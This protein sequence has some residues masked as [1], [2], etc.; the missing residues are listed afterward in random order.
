MIVQAGASEA[1]RDLAARTAEVIFTA[2][3]TL[4]D[5][6]EFYADVKGRL[7]KYGRSPDDL[8]IMPGAF[9]IIGRTEAEAQEKYEFLQSLKSFLMSPGVILKN[10]YKG[11]DLSK[12]SLDDVAS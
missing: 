1:G 4:A 2:N 11:V 7:A 8:K 12:Y 10:Y 6:Q 3:Q 9:P 5:A